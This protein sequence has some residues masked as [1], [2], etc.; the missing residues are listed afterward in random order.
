MRR[1]IPPVGKVSVLSCLERGWGM[2]G[3]VLGASRRSPRRASSAGRAGRGAPSHRSKEISYP[4]NVSLLGLPRYSPE[5]NPLERWFQEF[6]RAL[7]NRT[8]E[9]IELLQEALTQTLEPYWEEPARLQ[10]LTGFSWWVKAVSALC[11]Q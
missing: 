5:L 6:R 11:H 3:D 7:S 10:R 2:L 8:F 9:T 4:Q 1:W